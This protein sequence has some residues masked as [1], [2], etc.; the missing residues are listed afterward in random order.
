[1]KNFFFCIIVV[2]CKL[3]TVWNKY[4]LSVKKYIKLERQKK[5]LRKNPTDIGT[6]NIC[7]ILVTPFIPNQ[8]WSPEQDRVH[9]GLHLSITWPSPTAGTVSCFLFLVSGVWDPSRWWLERGCDLCPFWKLWTSLT[10]WNRS[11]L[12]ESLCFQQIQQNK[13]SQKPIEGMQRRSLNRFVLWFL[14]ERKDGTKEQQDTYVE[15]LL[16]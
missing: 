9:V 3:Y 15:Y 6:F 14:Q 7:T 5:W 8:S 12:S 2:I 10:R 1:M 16:V 11:N 13:K 4:F